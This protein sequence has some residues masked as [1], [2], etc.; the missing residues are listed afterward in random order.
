M[1]G[2]GSSINYKSYPQS[3]FWGGILLSR[4]DLSAQNISKNE[5]ICP[6]FSIA[7]YTYNIEKIIEVE[8]NKLTHT[9]N[10]TLE[11]P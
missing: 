4:R 11:G 7:L 6:S 5:D 10:Q 1:S 3:M 8:R 9:Y 2:A